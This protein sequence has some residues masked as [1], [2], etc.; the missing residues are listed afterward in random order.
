MNRNRML[1][2]IVVLIVL[3]LIL[4]GQQTALANTRTIENGEVPFYARIE[5]TDGNLV[6]AVFYRPPECIPNDFNLLDFFDPVNA[7]DCQAPTTEGFMVWKNG[8]E[9]DPG[10]YLSVLKG[11][12]AV[13][14]WFVSLPD[15]ED[16]AAD[17]E[18]TIGEL[19]SLPSLQVGY[20]S[21]YQ[22]TLRPYEVAV[23]TTV[24]VEARGTLID[25]RAFKLHFNATEANYNVKISIGN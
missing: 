13:P 1:K 9:V 22:E 2:G 5:A 25:G 17:G 18:L 6:A 24:L 14:I 3:A 23:T 8:P 16:A 21:F 19:A 11:R 7:W 15:F 4:G 20:A 10:P 12:G